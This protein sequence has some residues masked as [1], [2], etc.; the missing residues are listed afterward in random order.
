MFARSRVVASLAI[1][2][3]L[4]AAPASAAA[5]APR[6]AAS[7]WT[8]ASAAQPKAPEP[9]SAAPQSSACPAAGACVALET[10]SVSGGPPEPVALE[11]HGSTWSSVVV[12][13]PPAGLPSASAESA[14]D[15]LACWA[16][17]DCVAPVGASSPTA[18]QTTVLLLEQSSRWTTL[19]ASS[20]VGSTV[21][22]SG[23][24]TCY[25]PGFGEQTIWQLTGTTL[26]PVPIPIP[27][28][29]SIS[30]LG[31][32]ACSS[33]G[34]CAAP[35]KLAAAGGVAE[36]AIVAG[37]GGAW[38]VTPVAAPPGSPA[39]ALSL[40]AAACAP[41]GVCSLA[42]VVGAPAQAESE[43]VVTGSGTAWSPQLLPSGVPAGETPS[44]ASVQQ[45]ECPADGSCM[46]FGSVTYGPSTAETTAASLVAQS[47]GQWQPQLLTLPLYGTSWP[48]LACSAESYCLLAAGAAGTP[49]TVVAGG[50]QGFSQVGIS[51]P[52]T[53]S[54]NP[55]LAAP[56]CVA[57]GPC[58]CVGWS[59]LQSPDPTPLV[60]TGDPVAGYSAQ[61]P[62]GPAERLTN[63][64]VEAVSCLSG[65]ACVAAGRSGFGT[66]AAFLVAYARTAGGWSSRLLPLPTGAVPYAPGVVCAADG[67][68]C[69]VED[70]YTLAYGN[71]EEFGVLATYRAGRWSEAAAPLPAG[72]G[73]A[74]VELSLGDLS[75]PTSKACLVLGIYSSTT[76]GG[77][78]TVVITRSASGWVA[79]EPSLG[80]AAGK[81][82][83]GGV[84]CPVA[85]WCLAVG[86]GGEP[87]PF[88]GFLAT[89]TSDR[90]TV[91]RTG[92]GQ[93]LGAPFC[94][95]AGN[96]VVPVGDSSDWYADVAGGWHAVTGTGADSIRALSCAP[97]GSCLAFGVPTWSYDAA[98]TSLLQGPIVPI[99]TFEGE[100]CASGGCVIVGY[101]DSAVAAMAT[102]AA[103]GPFTT[104]DAPTLAGVAG[105]AALHGAS[106]WSATGCV[107][108]GLDGQRALFETLAS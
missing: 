4:L 15:S 78:R 55:D 16:P 90:W 98:T 83:L 23:S 10:A 61:V 72:A 64:S 34:S 108:V 59:P 67:S 6:S 87:G 44:G 93:P 32:L 48:S 43:V 28:G 38:H 29:D 50:V 27:A 89:R 75:C 100:S 40:S 8:P 74:D 104:T 51:L 49:A 37:S 57:G 69:V 85:G 24:G 11:Q 56:A 19:V 36:P 68:G 54:G 94:W 101:D 92:A 46:V 60:V 97:D 88:A 12:P 31:R 35:A 62:P 7:A 82:T 70:T 25:I 33:D 86:Q 42:G 58:A 81:R 22:C 95:S 91:L 13:W 3:G 47:G 79:G 66:Q 1:A 17:G 73:G 14:P 105:T 53:A 63:A 71:V 20:E 107:A 76:S 5:G 80:A 96:C 65:S 45:I 26:A 2:V 30:Y 99:G 77:S 102:G 21:A 39:G 103:T 18:P 41:G 106:C 84:S 52:G 9:L